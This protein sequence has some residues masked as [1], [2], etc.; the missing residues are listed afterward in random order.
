M[1]APRIQSQKITPCLWF[2]DNAEEAVKFYQSVFNDTEVTQISRYGKDAPL[3]E[4]TALT[5]SM[6]LY[7]QNFL[8]LNGGPAFTFNEAVSFI[9]NCE[10]QQEIDTF[11]AKLSDG[12]QTQQCGWLKDKYG[13]S[14]QVV[15]VAL[16][17]LLKGDARRAGNV[18]QALMQMVKID[19]PALEKAYNQ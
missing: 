18:M 7:G 15:P 13:L 10:T 14:W 17:S 8:L 19:L 12:G 1:E 2:K 9:I 16:A 5:I 11:W 3:P 6:R 4:G